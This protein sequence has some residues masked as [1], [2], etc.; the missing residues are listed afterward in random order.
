[1][2]LPKS[3]LSADLLKLV[4]Q[5]IILGI[6]P[7]HLSVVADL[8]PAASSVTARIDR[9]EF[10]GADLLLRLLVGPVTLFA[11][12]AAGSK[13]VV[14]RQVRVSVPLSRA[15]YYGQSGGLLA[16]QP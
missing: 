8:V 2:V 4:G 15:L 5:E 12:V 1:L 14:G 7:E 16:S 10:S 6:R 3:G 13:L 9:V 11:R